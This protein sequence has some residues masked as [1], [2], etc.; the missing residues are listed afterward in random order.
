MRVVAGRLRNQR[1]EAPPGAATRPTSERAREA[2]FNILTNGRFRDLLPEATVADLF[3]GSGAVGIEALSRGAARALFAETDRAA[4]TA[5]RANVMRLKLADRAQVLAVDATRLPRAPVA[6]Q[7][8]FLDPPYGQDLA[9]PA[10]ASARA[11]GW[12]A[13]DGVAA[14]QL[15][16][17]DRFAPP[18]DMTVLADRRY[19]AA[20]LVLLAPGADAPSEERPS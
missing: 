7:L 13:P 2:L 18:A 9:G 1:L 3:A 4:L 19:G 12:L 14:V 11:G 17:K 10:L 15:H 6:C 8:V 20:R 16:P 5:L